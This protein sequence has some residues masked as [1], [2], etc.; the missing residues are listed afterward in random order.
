MPRSAKGTAESMASSSD[1]PRPIG[2]TDLHELYPAVFFER[3]RDTPL[4]KR[5][6]LRNKESVQQL[7]DDLAG[8]YLGHQPRWNRDSAGCRQGTLTTDQHGSIR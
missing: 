5:W 2:V 7:A 6:S 4:R 1:N 3:L 8:S